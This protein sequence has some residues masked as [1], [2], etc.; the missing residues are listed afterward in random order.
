M[1]TIF[2][3][4]RSFIIPLLLLIEPVTAQ[5]P[6]PDVG[7]WP[8][9]GQS[10]CSISG[11]CVWSKDRSCDPSKANQSSSQGLLYGWWEKENLLLGWIIWSYQW[12]CS[13]LNRKVLSNRRQW[14]QY[15]KRSRDETIRER[16]RWFRPN[17]GKGDKHNSDYNNMLYNVSSDVIKLFLRAR[18]CDHSITLYS[19]VPNPRRWWLLLFP[20]PSWE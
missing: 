17:D 12:L 16:E 8:R 6:Q 19:P 5:Y 18:D 20:F 9:S 2:I 10:K 14:G 15:S 7:T 3:C 1:V 13:L 4:P 11:N